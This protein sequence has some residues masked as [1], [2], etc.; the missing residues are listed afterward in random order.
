MCRKNAP[1]QEIWSADVAGGHLDGE[2]YPKHDNYYRTRPPSALH[3][4]RERINRRLL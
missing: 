2:G 4:E 3:V 1:L